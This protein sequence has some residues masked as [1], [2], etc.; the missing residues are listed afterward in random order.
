MRSCPAPFL[1]MGT[2]PVTVAAGTGAGNAQASK[3]KLPQELGQEDDSV[4][5]SEGD[6]VGL[7]AVH[8][9][10]DLQVVGRFPD[11]IGAIGLVAGD[12]RR[13]QIA[14]NGG[15]QA[16]AHVQVQ[17]VVEVEMGFAK[18][19]CDDGRDRL[20]DGELLALSGPRSPY[21]GKLGVVEEGALADL[22]LVDGN[23]LENLQPIE[24]PTKTSW[25]A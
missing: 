6:E 19:A 10:T 14:A 16:I 23:S 7:A 9:D 13:S 25:S 18:P 24:D 4:G 12:L 3:S 21:P 17:P 15:I 11:Q 8:L 5:I 1:K 20:A 2:L 22:L